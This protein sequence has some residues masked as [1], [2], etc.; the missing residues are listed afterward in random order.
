MNAQGL[1][2]TRSHV[3]HGIWDL[4]PEH[5]GIVSGPLGYKAN[6]RAVRP[7]GQCFVNLSR[8]KPYWE[9][10]ERLPRPMSSAAA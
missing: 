3:Y 1:G 6:R 4:V 5:Q 8:Q 10:V 9:G 2:L 7:L